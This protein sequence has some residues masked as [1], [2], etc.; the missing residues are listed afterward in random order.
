MD[1]LAIVRAAIASGDD[2]ELHVYADWLE[3]HG[4]VARAQLVHLQSELATTSAHD[5]RVLELGWEIELL[6][7]EH[8][9]RW[10]GELPVLEGV[11]WGEIARG[12]VASVKVRDVATLAMHA[13]AIAAAAPIAKVELISFDEFDGELPAMPWLR[14]LRARTPGVRYNASPRLGGLPREVEIA[15]T[16][17]DP[18]VEFLDEREAGTLERLSIHGASLG[19]EFAQA[20]AAAPWAS[21]LRTLELPSHY[22]DDNSGYGEDPTLRAAGAKALGKLR[23]LERLDVA[24]QQIGTQAL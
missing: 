17:A 8:G 11:E 19:R 2:A 15:S 10:R 24:R 7:A 18:N 14:T 5:R 6:L 20:L 23:T 13:N 12:F 21:G 4:D 16:G 9:E 22:V 3:Q 1:G